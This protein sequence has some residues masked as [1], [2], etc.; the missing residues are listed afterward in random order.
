MVQP[1]RSTYSRRKFISGAGSIAAATWLFEHVGR[2]HV[3]A[4]ELDKLPVAA[5]VT[6]YNTNSHAD[7]I[8]GKILSGWQ[9]NGG[10]GPAL[11]LVAMYVD[12]TGRDDLSRGLSDKHGFKLAQSIDEAITLGTDKVQVAGVLSIGEHGNY[13][14]TPDTGQKMYPRRRLFEQIASSFER[15][16]SVVP[17]FNDKHLAYNWADAKFMVDTARRMGIPLLAGSSVPV[18]MRE[19]A[20]ELNRDT[21]FDE[22]LSIGYGGLESYGIHALEGHQAMIE[23]R[24]GGESGIAS[25]QALQGEAIYRAAADNR[26][27]V[28]LFESILAALPR[29]PSA[30]RDWAMK[31]NTALYLLEHRDGLKSAVAMIGGLAPEFAFAAKL[32]GRATPMVTRFKLQEGAPYS[33]F[34][35][36]LKAIE[37][38]IH[39]R[40]AAYPVERTLLTTGALDRLMHSLAESGARIDTPE[41][42][43]QYEP[44]DWK[45]ANHSQSALQLTY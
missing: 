43:I 26:W 5:V 25:V 13:P 34:A 6:T 33:H 19:P 41:L 21:E 40:K 44:A 1:S 28:E 9:Q 29:R 7:V 31:K 2:V 45:F 42:A 3:R 35:H 24:R 12:Q 16:G 22:V 14:D 32:K 36:L 4:S 23:R 8:V 38:T 18:S 10:D 37:E 30:S 39:K 11:K 27:S 15:C 20:L 17:V